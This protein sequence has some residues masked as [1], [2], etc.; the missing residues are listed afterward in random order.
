MSKAEIAQQI[1]TQFACMKLSDLKQC[2]A[3][4]DAIAYTRVIMCLCAMPP[5][6]Q[7]IF[8]AAYVASAMGLTACCKSAGHTAYFCVS[9]PNR[10]NAAEQLTILHKHTHNAG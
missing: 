10:R 4:Q 7:G 2:T 5:G 1:N 3:S 8:A 9:M 6:V